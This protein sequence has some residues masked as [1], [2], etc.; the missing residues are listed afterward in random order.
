MTNK[1]DIKKIPG[2]IKV[3]P[4]TLTVTTYGAEAEYN[5]NALTADGAIEAS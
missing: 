2:T 5:G 3:T 4:A 1:L